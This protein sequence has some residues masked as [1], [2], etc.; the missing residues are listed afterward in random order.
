MTYTLA[1]GGLQVSVRDD[2]HGSVL[3]LVNDERG[4]TLGDVEITKVPKGARVI[5][6]DQVIQQIIVLRS[7]FA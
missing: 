6:N 4:E 5:V 2:G 3:V 1:T 7:R